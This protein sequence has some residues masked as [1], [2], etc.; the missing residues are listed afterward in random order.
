MYAQGDKWESIHM[1]KQHTW[2]QRKTEVVT[3]HA[4]TDRNTCNTLTR[5]VVQRE[6]VGSGRFRGSWLIQK[7]REREVIV[8]FVRHEAGR[9]S[10]RD[11]GS[12]SNPYTREQR[13]HLRAAAKELVRRLNQWASFRSLT[14]CTVGHKSTVTVTVCDRDRLSAFSCSLSLRYVSVSYHKWADT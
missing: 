4:H 10:F 5:F 9:C 6:I 7:N 12:K 3:E 14:A 13:A 1:D 11:S 2:T 8:R